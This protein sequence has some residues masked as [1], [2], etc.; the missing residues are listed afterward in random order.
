VFEMMIRASGKDVRIQTHDEP[1]IDEAAAVLLVEEYA[2][3][4]F[5]NRFA[6]D[7]TLQLALP[8]CYFD[9]HPHNGAPRKEGECCAT[10]VADALQLTP[11]FPSLQRVLKY[12]LRDDTQGSGDHTTLGGTMKRLHRAFP[13]DTTRTMCWAIRG[14]RAKL[15]E[16]GCCSKDFRVDA[17]R[18]VI[19]SLVGDEAATHWYA[20][21]VRADNA[22]QN[23]QQIAEAEIADVEF[24]EVC[25]PGNVKVTIAVIE[26]DNPRMHVVALAKGATIVIKKEGRGNVQ[27]FSRLGS[28]VR[29]NGV[30]RVLGIAEQYARHA[31]NESGQPQVL[32]DALLG[33]EGNPTGFWYYFPKMEAVFNGSLTERSVPATALPLPLIRLAV[34]EGLKPPRLR[35]G[36]AAIRRQVQECK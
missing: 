8:G 22:N 19:R 18:E 23:W 30:A 9:E 15:R 25:L 33:V 29:F 11:R 35:A 20:E 31:L 24:E 6:P 1:H 34:I 10:L 2:D 3:E 27:I 14:L 12:V 5:L 13:D 32:D 26:T 7:G 21:V 17:I 16:A 28:G 36:L 4:A